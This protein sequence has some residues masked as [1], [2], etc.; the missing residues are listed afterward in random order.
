MLYL[1]QKT[2]PLANFFFIQLIVGV[3][4]QLPTK[5]QAIVFK[6][7][8]REFIISNIECNLLEYL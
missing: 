4:I 8:Q 7:K 1:W 2:S 5:N 6:F 3:R